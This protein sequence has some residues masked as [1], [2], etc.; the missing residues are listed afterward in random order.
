MNNIK[1]FHK[2]LSELNC[3]GLR[4]A[5]SLRQRL[6]QTTSLLA[7]SRDCVLLQ[8]VSELIK[9]IAIIRGAIRDP[10]IA[11]SSQVPIE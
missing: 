3:D 6:R 8:A 11:D 1:K 9:R 4:P 5:E 10:L 2:V 7:P